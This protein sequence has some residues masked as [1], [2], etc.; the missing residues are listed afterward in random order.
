MLIKVFLPTTISAPWSVSSLWQNTINGSHEVTVTSS[1]PTG[2]NG[3]AD[4]SGAL[5]LHHDESVIFWPTRLFIVWIIGVV[6]STTVV[7]FQYRRLRRMT[8]ALPEIDEG[9]VKVAVEQAA[10]Q[11]HLTETPVVRLSQEHVS[12]FLI[13]TRRPCIVVPRSLVDGATLQELQTVLLHEVTHWRHRDTWIGWWQVIVQCLLWFHPF[14][15]F[16][17]G[18]L[19]HERETVCDEA[20]LRASAVGPDEYGETLLRVLTVV[21]GRSLVTDSLVGVFERGGH[22]Q[23]RLESVM[24]FETRGKYSVWQSVIGVAAFALLFLPMAPFAFK[25]AVLADAGIPVKVPTSENTAN[26][27]ADETETT[28]APARRTPYPEIVETQPAAGSTNVDP[29]LKELRVTFDRDMGEGMS[30][31]G[32]GDA[33]P[34]IPDGGKPEW[35]QDGR[36]CTIPVSLQADHKYTPGLNSLSHNNFQSKWGVPIKPV[37]YTFRTE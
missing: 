34:K 7:V 6:V 32:G 10:M 4:T 35:S 19:R 20:V 29:A 18:R 2:F 11:L 15:W 23:N 13:G 25:D 27:I 14:V 12:P 36:T 22:I 31:T 21:R 26:A 5:N 37:V 8:A 16:A 28:S 9:P 33:F 3:H 17:N 30:W 1:D 24:Q